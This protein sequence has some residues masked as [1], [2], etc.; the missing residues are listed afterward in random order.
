MAADLNDLADDDDVKAV[1]IRVNS[2]GGSSF[3][4][5]QIWHAIKELRN[6]KPVVVSMGGYAA[7]G[8]YYISSPANYIVAEPTTLTGSIG[9]YGL[10]YDRSKLL[11]SMHSSHRLRPQA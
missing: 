5:D 11:S 4:S 2:P 3:A 9:V 8:G 7:S 10:M 6:H 1:V